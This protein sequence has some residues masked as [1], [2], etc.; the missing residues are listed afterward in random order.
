MTRERDDAETAARH[1][2]DRASQLHWMLLRLA[3]YIPDE[4]LSTCRQWLFEGKYSDVATTVAHVASASGVKMTRGDIDL[5][6]AVHRES[7]LGLHYTRIAISEVA[8]ISCFA[9]TRR[10]RCRPVHSLAIS[11]G[12]AELGEALKTWPRSTLCGA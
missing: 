11:G 1:V 2:G 6:A 7:N 8:Q 4:A 12:P 10:L 5:L 9:V 3:G